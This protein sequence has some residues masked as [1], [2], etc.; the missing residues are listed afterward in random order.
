MTYTIENE[1]VTSIYKVVYDQNKLEELLNKIVRECSYKIKGKFKHRYGEIS[2][3]SR[4]YRITKGP[5]LPNGDFLYQDI[6]KIDD[7]FDGLSCEFNIIEC[8]E[9]IVPQLANIVAAII[10]GNSDGIDLLQAYANSNEF[11]SIDTAMDETVKELREK[12]NSDERDIDGLIN[13]L[14]TLKEL[15]NKQKENQC[16][17]IELL[18]LYYFEVVNSINFELVNQMIKPRGL[19]KM[20]TMDEIF[21]D[22]LRIS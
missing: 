3:I 2:Y 1:K 5:Q 7:D 13:S 16:F 15:R 4:P 20:R 21:E 12:I 17:N 9:V 14:D 18:K 8:S 6:T 22:S 11:V 10:N 19:V